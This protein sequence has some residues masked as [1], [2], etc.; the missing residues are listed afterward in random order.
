MAASAVPVKKPRVIGIVILSLIGGVLSIL[1]AIGILAIAGDPTYASVLP[2]WVAPLGYLTLVLG[3]LE[4]LGAVLLLMYRKLGLYLTG[5]LYVLNLLILVVEIVTGN[6][7]L[8]ITN[9][10]SILLGLAVLYYVYIYL[11]R[12]PDKTFFK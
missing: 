12:E 8:S 10:L 9:I 1:G 6:A 7:T 3:V 11:T 4:L 2:G 5:G